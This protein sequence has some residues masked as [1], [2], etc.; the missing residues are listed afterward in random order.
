MCNT[1]FIYFLFLYL[2]FL[3]LDVLNREGYTQKDY[4]QELKKAFHLIKVRQ[5]KQKHFAK[6][7]TAR[8]N[9][10]TYE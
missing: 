8:I 6:K 5:F 7:K 3:I 2:H 1:F 9:I 10:C 4:L